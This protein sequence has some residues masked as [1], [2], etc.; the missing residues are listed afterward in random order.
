MEKEIDFSKYVRENQ[1]K[2]RRIILK[3]NKRRLP[4][5]R[6]RNP[7]EREILLK[8][9]KARWEKWIKEGKIKEI[10]EREW[11]IKLW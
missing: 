10:G 7:K 1:T 2:F 3:N 6:P 11:E 9:D 4:R 8:L 5:R